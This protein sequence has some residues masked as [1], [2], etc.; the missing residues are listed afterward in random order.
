MARVEKTV[1]ISYR[2]K[3]ISWALAV[4]QYL[5]SRKY[6]VFFDYTSIPSGD[7]EQIIVS[8][9]RARAHFILILTPTS[10]DRCSEPGDWLRREIETAME[11]RRNI[12]PLFFDGFDFRSPSVL[13]KLT[14]GLKNLDRYNGFEV[15]AGFFL[16]AMERMRTKYLS[17]PLDAVIHPVPADVQKKVEKEQEA[18]NKAVLAQR[19]T[20]QEIV[21][22]AGSHS[23]RFFGISAALLVAVVLGMYGISSFIQ[24]VVQSN[25][26]TPDGSTPGTIAAQPQGGSTA[27]IKTSTATAQPTAVPTLGVGSIKVSDVDGMPMAYIPAGEFEMGS[28]TGAED[29]RPVHT[30]Y[31]DAYWID[32]TE[33][34]NAMYAKCVETG[35]CQFP[36]DTGSDTL[37]N[38]FSDPNFQEYPVINIA[39]E[40]AENYCSWANRRLPTEAEWEKAA[41]WDEREQ[42]KVYYPWSAEMDCSLAN[43]KDS[44]F[45]SCVGDTMPVGSYINSRNTYG[46]FDLVGNVWEWTADWYDEDYYSI[47]PYENPK[48]PGSGSLKVMRGGSFLNDETKVSP[49]H[50]GQNIPSLAPFSAGIRCAVSD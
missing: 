26:V 36:I 2:R 47:S 21:R 6:D 13:D 30:V 17:V 23:R 31:L 16:E 38:Y 28:E 43:Y 48:G 34:T 3:D 19:R 15:P 39:F 10:L 40:M 8:N 12:V 45:G 27:V 20:I 14:G 29:E 1:F 22:P 50:R 33:V 35:I 18:A 11:E 41:T 5:T 44:E 49:T 4:Y 24:G 25:N 42:R 9:I 46:I 37:A 7:F 32:Q